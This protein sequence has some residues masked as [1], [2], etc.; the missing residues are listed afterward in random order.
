[1]L[2]LLGDES[3]VR[4][5]DSYQGIPGV[6]ARRPVLLI[7]LFAP[8]FST[9]SQLSGAR[10]R[11]S[12]T[13]DRMHWSLYVVRKQR[14]FSLPVPFHLNLKRRA[15]GDQRRNGAFATYAP[16]ASLGPATSL[17]CPFSSVRDSTRHST[18][19]VES[20]SPYKGPIR[21]TPPPPVLP[22]SPRP[23]HPLCPPRV[24]SW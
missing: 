1:M 7:R 14:V 4:E 21:A 10:C 9:L 5:C 3:S 13:H 15:I 17:G 8:G 24:P 22:S 20:G 11:L 23:L 19:F 16:D 2:I 12:A 6:C 18:R